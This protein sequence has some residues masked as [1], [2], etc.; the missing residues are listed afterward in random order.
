M[1]DNVSMNRGTHLIKFGIE[2]NWERP[3]GSGN[4]S[5]SWG[6]Y[7]FT[8][9][10]SGSDMGDF[11]LEFPARRKSRPPAPPFMPA[12]STSDSSPRTTGR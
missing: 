12:G 9:H 4:S 7:H 8:G 11:L 5:N 3:F 6:V 1:K 2:A 10:Y